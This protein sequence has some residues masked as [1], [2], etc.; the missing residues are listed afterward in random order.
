MSYNVPISERNKWSVRVTESVKKK[1]HPQTLN[2]LI[3]NPAEFPNTLKQL[4]GNSTLQI[5]SPF[6]GFWMAAFYLF[7][8]FFLGWD[9]VCVRNW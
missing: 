1:F 2:L 9:H 3:A 4:V 8:D 7:S 6:P 5:L